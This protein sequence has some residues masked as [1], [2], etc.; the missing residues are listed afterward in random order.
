[1][2]LILGWRYSNG[3]PVPAQMLPIS[4]A[5]WRTKIEGNNGIRDARTYRYNNRLT[6]WLKTGRQDTR[7][8]E[9]EACKGVTV[10]WGGT[11]IDKTVHA[12]EITKFKVE[13][14]SQPISSICASSEAEYDW[15]VWLEVETSSKLCSSCERRSSSV[16]RCRHFNS[17]SWLFHGTVCYDRYWK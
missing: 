12:E 7:R 8:K 16:N 5:V 17:K 4:N 15:G 14:T 9:E 10:D 11:A 3:D 13:R 6:L 2:L 1:M